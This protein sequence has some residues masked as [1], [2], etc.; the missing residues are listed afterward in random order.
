MR[1]QASIGG[2]STFPQ[3]SMFG[4]QSRNLK[5][6]CAFIRVHDCPGGLRVKKGEKVSFPH[7]V[8]TLRR[9]S[10]LLVRTFLVPGNARTALN[11][12]IFL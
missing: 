3:S 6:G 1:V 5:Q 8:P 2:H 10:D 11:Q 4:A 12:I 7:R 9:S